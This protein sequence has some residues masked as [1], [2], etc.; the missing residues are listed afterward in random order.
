LLPYCLANKEYTDSKLGNLEKGLPQEKAAPLMDR[1]IFDKVS[2]YILIPS[3][4]FIL[5]NMVYMII[6]C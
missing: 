6:M 1:L 4:F 3:P 5:K 2:H